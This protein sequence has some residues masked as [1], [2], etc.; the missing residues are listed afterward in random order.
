MPQALF[1]H[2]AAREWIFQTKQKGWKDF[3]YSDPLFFGSDVP[4]WDHAEELERLQKI[5]GSGQ[6]FEDV[7][8]NNFAAF[9]GREL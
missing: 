8:W 2:P 9:Y 1:D 5:T 7:C 6:L 3:R 4:M